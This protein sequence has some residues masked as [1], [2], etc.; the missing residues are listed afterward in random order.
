M[1]NNSVQIRIK[2]STNKRNDLVTAFG[3]RNNPS[4]LFQKHNSVCEL[5]IQVSNNE[6]GMQKKA[7]R[8]SCPNITPLFHSKILKEELAKLKVKL[9]NLKIHFDQ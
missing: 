8:F 1:K 5:P 9:I 7:R 6:N 4:N 2:T 3:S